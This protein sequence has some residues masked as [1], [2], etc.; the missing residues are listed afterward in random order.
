MLVFRCDRCGQCDTTGD[1][2]RN[3]PAG[4]ATIRAEVSADAASE[5]P[6]SSLLLHLCA[7]CWASTEPEVMRGYGANLGESCLDVP[8]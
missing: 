8:G 5:T 4:W 1:H 6:S 2:A 3:L 7:P